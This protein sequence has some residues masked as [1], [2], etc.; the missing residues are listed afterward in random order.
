[1]HCRQTFC[2]DILE[3]R[4]KQRKY[5]DL[6][7]ETAVGEV[8]FSAFYVVFF[9]LSVEKFAGFQVFYW[10]WTGVLRDLLLR[11]FR[12]KRVLA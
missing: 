12:G 7:L 8:L 9:D 2:S 3:I 11:F 10:F 6:E 4:L 1:M 5:S